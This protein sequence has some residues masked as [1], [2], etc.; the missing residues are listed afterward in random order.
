MYSLL[1]GGLTP[2]ERLQ[3]EVMLS[4]L[5]SVNVKLRSINV[6]NLIRLSADTTDIYIDKQGNQRDLSQAIQEFA[7]Q[8]QGDA[9]KLYKEFLLV[10]AHENDGLKYL[11]EISIRRRIKPGESP[12]HVTVS[13][14]INEFKRENNETDEQLQ[15]RLKK[16]ISKSKVLEETRKKYLKSFKTFVETLNLQLASIA[17]LEETLEQLTRAKMMVP[18][19]RGSSKPRKRSQASSLHQDYYYFEDATDYLWQWFFTMSDHASDR[20]IKLFDLVDEAGDKLTQTH[21][22]YCDGIELSDK[23]NNDSDS[24]SSWIGDFFSSDSDSSSSSSSCSSC[25]SCGGGD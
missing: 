15:A 14:V 17:N 22:T 6:E 1:T 9:A 7:K 4:I 13:A 8:M 16:V 18:H 3:T 12:V 21:D 5:Q 24:G 20:E 11:V 10:L 23:S 19:S 2:T 25:S